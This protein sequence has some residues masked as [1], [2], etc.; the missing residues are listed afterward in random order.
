[1]RS[2]QKTVGIISY[3]FLLGLG[4]HDH[5]SETNADAPAR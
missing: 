1:M 4:R 2:S 5:S 3:T